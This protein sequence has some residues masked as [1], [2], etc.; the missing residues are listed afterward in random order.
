M[1]QRAEASQSNTVDGQSH[2]LP[3][4]LSWCL[5]SSL[6]CRLRRHLLL[7]RLTL[8]LLRLLLLQLLLLQLLL[9]QL[10]LLLLLLP[11]RC[12]ADCHALAVAMRSVQ[13][14]QKVSS[15]SQQPPWL[16]AAECRLPWHLFPKVAQCLS[17]LLP[18][19]SQQLL[20]PLQQ[21]ARRPRELS[22]LALL[23]A[24]AA[25]SSCSRCCLPLLLHQGYAG[26]DP[27]QLQG[28]NM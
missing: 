1:R 16:C 21:R 11:E 14:A 19:C 7:T 13:Q 12:Q 22:Q 26:A 8:M 17:R 10:L 28:P 6:P 23:A 24:G 5:L 3:L 27:T 20:P 25:I 4:L 2:A 18:G 9:L 15:F